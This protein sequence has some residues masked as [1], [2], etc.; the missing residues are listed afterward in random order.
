MKKQFKGEFFAKTDRGRIRLTNDDQA[1]AIT[2]SNGD[3]L[4]AVADGMGG[5]K[6]GDYASNM[7]VTLLEDAFRKVHSFSS[8]T[9][10]RHWLGKTIRR[11]NAKIYDEGYQK[12]D[13]K[14][15]GTTLVV[16]LIFKG[17]VMIANVGDS[18]AYR[19][20]YES[21]KAVTQD[22][23]YVEYLYQTGQIKAEEIKTRGDRHVLMNAV[24]I[25]PSLSVDIK[26]HPNL[27]Q[28]LILCSDGL[29]NNVS[30]ADI[31]A[32]LK[33]DE[34]VETKV[35]T[36]ISVANSNGG[37]DNIAIAYWEPLKDDKNW[38]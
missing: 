16:A 8:V 17:N 23:T 38:R 37:S 4:L 34:R 30:E 14:D 3:V 7:A 28:A 10:T 29:Y 35:E 33:T 9:L 36:L 6:K 15:M 26:T 19:V 11:I 2:N 24:G 21:V 27:N 12:A 1:L 22:Q 31:H 20:T 13:Y 32:I 5:H 25:F 18:R